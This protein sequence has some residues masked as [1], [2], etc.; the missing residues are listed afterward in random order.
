MRHKVYQILFVAVFMASAASCIMVVDPEKDETW[1]PSAEFRKSVDF[2]SGGTMAVEH[3]LGNIAIAG[4]DKDSLEVVATGRRPEP[5][6]RRQVHLYSAADIEPSVDI[7]EAGGATRIRTRSLGGPWAMGGLDYVINVPHSVN[8][9]TIRLE[10]GD[11][12]ISDVYGRAAVS[13]SKGNLTVKNFSG[14]LKAVLDEGQADV[15]LLDI[16]G[17]DVIEI[18]C[19]DGDIVLRLEP[20]AGATVKAQAPKGQVTSE[21]DLGRSL[22]AK[23]VSGRMGSGEAAITLKTLH[24]NIKILKAGGSRPAVAG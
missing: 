22:P 24:G 9:D 13:V 14:P 4:W 21:Y 6:S 18:S 23:D 15:E 12:T 17:V 20:D 11:L 10:H 3:T 19:K 7:R 1:Q 8:L 2:Q 16:R 5:A